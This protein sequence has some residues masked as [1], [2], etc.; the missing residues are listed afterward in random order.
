MKT[1]KQLL[2]ERAQVTAQQTDMVRV[3]EKENRFLNDEEKQRFDTFESDFTRLTGEMEERK[4]YDAVLSRQAEQ[5]HEARKNPHP[6][7]ENQ[8]KPE[9]QER[10]AF[11]K[12]MVHGPSALDANELRA[13]QSRQ[14]T[15]RQGEIRGTDP[16]ITATAALGGYLIPQG[17][18]NEL[19]KRMLYHGG[20]LEAARFYP[21]GSGETIKWPT[22][23]DTSNSGVLYSETSPAVVVNDVT[24]GEK[25]LES[26]GYD[27]GIV[28]VSVYLMEDSYFNLETELADL[29]GD[30]LGRIANNRLT[31]GTGTSQPHGFV[32]AVNAVSGTINAQN[33]DVISRTDL[34]NLMH[35]V[36]RSYRNGPKVGYMFN[37]TTLSAIKKLSLG[38][39][40]DRPLW[41]LS[42][43][44]G[45]PDRV[46]GKQYWINNDM[47]DLAADA[48]AAAF[49][50]FN[51]YIYRRVN[52]IVLIP[53]RER[54]MDQLQI[55]FLA[56]IRFDGELIQPNAIKLLRNTNT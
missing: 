21:T 45:D 40:D 4:K 49:G 31:L 56:Y 32:T 53:L 47:A 1:Y 22:V 5:E 23:D 37:D 25:S 42:M 2:E 48:R 13:L 3:A 38:S 44:E 52:D 50:D 17:F 35:G 36:D 33:D 15:L 34:I 18:S 20:I 28:K 39:G 43:R 55:G 19:E 24:F 29:L 54:Y 51:K 14:R 7:N 10:S 41:Q 26:Y 8:P 30:R 16:Q 12:F 11:W 46:E 6:K 9:E 27:S